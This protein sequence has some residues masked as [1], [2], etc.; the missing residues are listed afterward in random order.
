MTRT[1]SLLEADVPQGRGV[2]DFAKDEP[3]FPGKDGKTRDL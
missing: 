3:A 2:G 1:F